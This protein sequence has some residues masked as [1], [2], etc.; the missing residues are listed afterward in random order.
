MTNPKRIIIATLSGLF[1]GMICMFLA[2]S[3]PDAT[4][5]LP[6]MV[7]WNIVISRGLMGFMIGIS[8]LRMQWWLHGL[9]L[10]LIASIP[11]AVAVADRMDIFVGT[12]VMGMI[13]GV[14]TELITSVFFKAKQVA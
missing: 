1:F 4:E 9:V 14:L 5:V 3:N 13:Y 11:M 12:F 8:A 6:A 2:S 7:K 10:G